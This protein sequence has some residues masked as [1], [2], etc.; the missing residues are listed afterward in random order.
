MP[1]EIPEMQAPSPK[2]VGSI[3]SPV[4]NFTT[5]SLPQTLEASEP[6]HFYRVTATNN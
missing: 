5:T 2:G 6:R 1:W 4:Y 3:S